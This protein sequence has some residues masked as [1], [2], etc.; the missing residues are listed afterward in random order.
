MLTTGRDIVM[1]PREMLDEVAAQ[2]L[3]LSDDRRIWLLTGDLGSGKTTLIQHICNRLGVVDAVHSPTF[4]L[5]NEYRTDTGTPIYHFDLYRLKSAREAYEIGL[6]EYVESGH[7]CF[8]EWPEA[9][10]PLWPDNCFRL[11]LSRNQAGERIISTDIHTTTNFN[12]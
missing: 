11:F 7:Y 10:Q 6:E 12:F 3:Q 2:L 1:E 5:V 4:S 9:A 8:V